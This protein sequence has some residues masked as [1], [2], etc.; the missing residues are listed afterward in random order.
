MLEDLN[1]WVEYRVRVD[2]TDALEFQE[3]IIMKEE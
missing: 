2:I 3:K 1:G